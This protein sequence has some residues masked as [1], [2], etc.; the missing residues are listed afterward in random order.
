MFKVKSRVA[1]SILTLVAVFGV[2][3]YA[4]A[5]V[6]SRA[7]K[8]TLTGGVVYISS[9]GTITMLHADVIATL[10][11]RGGGFFDLTET[12]QQTQSANCTFAANPTD[13][14]KLALCSWPNG[15][16]CTRLQVGDCKGGI[17]TSFSSCTTPGADC[18]G[19]VIVQ[20]FDGSPTEF[21]NVAKD[22]TIGIDPKV[23]A[24][25]FPKKNPD[26]PASAGTALMARVDQ[27]C[28]P[29]R[30]WEPED[31]VIRDVWR[32]DLSLFDRDQARFSSEGT[33]HALLD[34]TCNPADGIATGSCTQQSIINI[35]FPVSDA[36]ACSATNQVC[37]QRANG[38][39]GPPPRDCDFDKKSGQCTCAC[40]RCDEISTFVNVGFPPDGG[41][42]GSGHYTISDLNAKET[43]ACPLTLR[44]T[45]E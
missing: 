35:T 40:A 1:L 29:K 42:P 21:I 20:F 23:C 8:H 39:F 41:T 9:Q 28:N 38:T 14:P 2:S 3:I 10:T 19:T 7:H 24:E 34:A 25:E 5:H 4:W 16:T 6:I 17:R 44:G 26:F 43:A 31:R 30:A 27:V 13:K 45:T 37:G 32:T 33:W 22:P 11:D 12:T 18:T 15:L 36:K